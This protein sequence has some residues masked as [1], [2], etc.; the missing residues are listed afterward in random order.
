MLLLY[1]I[2]K[3]KV[4][5]KSACFIYAYFYIFG[6]RMTEMATVD[7][8]AVVSGISAYMGTMAF[9]CKH[10][11]TPA[12]NADESGAIGVVILAFGAA[13]IASTLVYKISTRFE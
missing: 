7:Y 8:V 6:R 2:V 9:G 3:K 1:M 5:K 10:L 4:I 13:A 11:M 12:L